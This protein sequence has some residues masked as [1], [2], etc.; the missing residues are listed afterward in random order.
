VI[1]KRGFEPV[2]VFFGGAFES[3][4]EG[5]LPFAFEAGV[6]AGEEVQ[7]GI[8]SAELEQTAHRGR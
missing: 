4:L 1:W 6:I 2:E 3:F 5:H 8:L 7:D